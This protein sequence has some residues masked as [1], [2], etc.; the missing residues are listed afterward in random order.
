M[1]ERERQGRQQPPVLEILDLKTQRLQQRGGGIFKKEEEA[2]F[3]KKLVQQP[4]EQKAEDEP[5]LETFLPEIVSYEKNLLVFLIRLT[6]NSAI[7][8]FD[9]TRQ[10]WTGEWRGGGDKR[11]FDGLNARIQC[12]W[13]DSIVFFHCTHP[14]LQ[15]A[16][17]RP[18]VQEAES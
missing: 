16:R 17:P 10:L 18:D 12:S 6:Q 14:F 11:Y 2:A 3:D 4:S 5:V 1:S 15:F 13:K 9:V 7:H 8:A